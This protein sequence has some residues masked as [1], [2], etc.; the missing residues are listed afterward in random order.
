[1]IISWF[2]T[3]PSWSK[4]LPKAEADNCSGWF[5]VRETMVGGVWIQYGAIWNECLIMIYEE[6]VQRGKRNCPQG[7]QVL[8][9]K[10]EE[11]SLLLKPRIYF[12][13]TSK[14]YET[15]A[16][17]WQFNEINGVKLWGKKP[18]HSPKESAFWCIQWN[19]L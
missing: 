14:V 5:T 7:S 8:S 18:R 2:S 9:N 1:M 4:I 16:Q 17:K 3:F 6:V 10:N 19:T 13:T 11:L 12:L 15:T